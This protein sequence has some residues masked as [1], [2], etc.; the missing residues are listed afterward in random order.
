MTEFGFAN[1][2]SKGLRILAGRG[3]AHAIF[4]IGLGVALPLALQYLLLGAAVS[5][6]APVSGA[7]GYPSAGNDELAL[8]VLGVGFVFQLGSYFA[9]WRIGL[10]PA[11]GIGRAAGF[12]LL[13]GLVATGG[14]AV[15]V[16][17]GAAL[18]QVSPGF[19]ALAVM[20][21]FLVMFA[22][23]QAVVAA[24]IAVALAL[25]LVLAIV[26]GASTGQIGLAATLVGGSGFAVVLLLILAAAFLWLT[27]RSS[28]AVA[29]MAA[30]P[31]FNPF[32]AIAESWR[33]TW[34]EQWR[35]MGYLAVIGL[36]LALL[37]LAAAVATGAAVNAALSG[38]AAPDFPL[39]PAL[40]SALASIPLAYLS[41]LVPAGIYRELVGTGAPVDVFA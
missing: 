12:G 39:D 29:V 13:A 30:R 9:S 1:A 10:G 34:E 35:I 3:V 7:A 6:L 17:A 31:T 38:D 21:A 24:L 22:L 14:V 33:L 32:A 20:I 18:A 19:G 4:L 2:W 15:L 25:M 5:M 36:V 41:V 23:F 8:A 27:A 28:C 16:A 11:A 37:G 40:F 26:F